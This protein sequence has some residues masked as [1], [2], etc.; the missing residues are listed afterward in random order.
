MRAVLAPELLCVLQLL[1]TALALDGAQ[2][3]QP[4][5]ALDLVQPLRERRLPLDQ[6][7]LAG[8]PRS[9]LDGQSARPLLQKLACSLEA[10]RALV[11]LP[12]PARARVILVVAVGWRRHTRERRRRCR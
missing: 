9:F 1:Q 4:L 7:Q 6:L 10:G 8:P 2:R 12:Q 11:D 5:A 3:D